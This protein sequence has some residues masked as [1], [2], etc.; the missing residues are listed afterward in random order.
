MPAIKNILARNTPKL[1]KI[2]S[3]PK[4]DVEVLLSFAIKK[5]KEFLYT[6]PE[7]KL[8]KK[9]ESNFNAAIKRRLKN[10]PI[11]YIIGEKEFYG[12]NFIVNKNTL[13]P[14]PETELIVEQAIQEIKKTKNQEIKYSPLS[15]RG[16]GGIFPTLRR[17]LSA[18]WRNCGDVASQEVGELVPPP[19]EGVGGRVFSRQ[20]ILLDIG[21]GSGCIP[22][23]IIKNLPKDIGKEIK[24]CAIDI[25]S[26][27]L[28]LAKKN[29]R[30]HG[31]EKEI[32]FI[33]SDLLDANL[34]IGI[35]ANPPSASW[36]TPCQGSD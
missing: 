23:S 13:I 25:S 18:H 35:T 26:K 16:V 29:A 7:Y 34:N 1:S 8:A 6:H 20:I 4:L 12:L 21:A 19:A 33:E 5:P 3:T 11:A 15:Q 2:S 28:I 30:L 22:I 27:A 24:T 17:S 9:Q 10:E 32:K 14:R 36:R 31:V